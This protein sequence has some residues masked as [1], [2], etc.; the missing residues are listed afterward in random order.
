MGTSKPIGINHI[1]N[2]DYDSPWKDILDYFFQPFVEM[3][4]SEAAAKIDWFRGYIA[5]DKELT[6]IERGQEIGKRVV[7]KLF[8]VWMKDGKELWLLFHIEV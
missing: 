4:L 2:A 1:A 8:K 5:L 6:A 7:D 3:C